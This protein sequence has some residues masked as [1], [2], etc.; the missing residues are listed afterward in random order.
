MNFQ[1]RFIGWR[2]IL[3]IVA[4]GVLALVFLYWI[5]NEL[6]DELEIALI[7]DEPWED[8]R[9]R[10]SATIGPAIPGHIWFRIPDSD[11]RLRFIDSQFGFTTPLARFFTISFGDERVRD[12][13]MSL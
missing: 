7:Y 5:S 13:R 1:R 6:S 4:L 10:S 11:A 3:C 12:I 9:Q 2:Q 8:M